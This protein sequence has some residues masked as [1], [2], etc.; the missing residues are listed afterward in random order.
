MG[1]CI[2][3]PDKETNYQCMKHNYYQCQECLE[4]KDPDIYCK[5]RSA[6]AIHFISKKGFESSKKRESEKG[7]ILE[8]QEIHH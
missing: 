2:N 6:C 3:H 1:K 4:C 5:F 8:K 7:K